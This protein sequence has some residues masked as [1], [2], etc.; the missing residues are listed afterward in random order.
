[1]IAAVF[2]PRLVVGVVA[3]AGRPLRAVRVE[4]EE[5]RRPDL[6][7]RVLRTGDAVDERLVRMLLGVVGD[8][9]A[10]VTRERA[11]EDVRVLLLHQPARLLDRLVGRVVAAAVADDL[12][13][14]A[15]HGG[16]L[17][18]VGR[19]RP[20]GLGARLVDQRLIEP[21]DRRLEERAERALAV[22]QE[23]DLDRASRLARR[24]A[25]L[26][27]AVATL[28]VRAASRDQAERERGASQRQQLA[29]PQLSL[30]SPCWTVPPAP[31]G[32]AGDPG[33]PPTGPSGRRGRAGR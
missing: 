25:L 18:A 1:M 11:D 24:T 2:Q 31:S 15:G 27:S 7:R 32:A 19:L 14:L 6:Q 17:D 5:V 9:D 21:G 20:G 8:R 23:R 29:C 22:R 4:A 13:L 16:A 10:L 3:Q 12:D 33:P 30:S 28:V 26:R